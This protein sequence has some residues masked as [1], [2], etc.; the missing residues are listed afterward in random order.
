M[1]L[2]AQGH[3]YATYKSLVVLK[4]DGGL[5]G[6]IP[7]PEQP[8]NCTFGGADGKT[9]Y[10]TARTSLY[11]LSMNVSGAALCTNG[12]KPAPAV[13]RVSHPSFRGPARLAQGAK[14]DP[15]DRFEDEQRGLKSIHGAQGS[16]Q[17]LGLV[18]RHLQQRV[19][20]AHKIGAV[21]SLP[22]EHEVV[23]GLPNG[24]RSQPV[25]GRPERH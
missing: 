17:A 9:L 22:V 2:D 3:I 14:E 11:S 24:V 15:A 5:I 18:Q 1:A 20:D 4:A 10:I 21:G 19:P 6:R 25:V 12:P 8:A 13:T 7:V 16:C 23:I